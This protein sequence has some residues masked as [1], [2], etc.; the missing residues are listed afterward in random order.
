M[1]VFGIVLV[2]VVTLIAFPLA[3]LKAES[4]WKGR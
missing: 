1:I 4:W 2:A 3:V